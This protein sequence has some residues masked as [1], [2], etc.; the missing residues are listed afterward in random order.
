MKNI[1]LILSILFLALPQI[2]AAKNVKKEWR[3]YK[4]RGV[5]MLKTNYPKNKV[6][7]A[8]KGF[9]YIKGYEILDNYEIDGIHKFEK[10]EVR[11]FNPLE[12]EVD[13]N[14]YKYRIKR[15]KKDGTPQD[16]KFYYYRSN[17]PYQGKTA[18]GKRP[19]L[20]ISPTIKGILGG[21]FANVE[22]TW[23]NYFAARGINV[24]ILKLGEKLYTPGQKT[25]ELNKWIQ[26]KVIAIRMMVDFANETL[27]DE[28]DT[29]RVA[30]YGA[31]LGGIRSVIAMSLEPKERIAAGVTVATG[32]NFADLWVTSNQKEVVAMREFMMEIE[33]I[34]TN[35]MPAR[36]FSKKKKKL[37]KKHYKGVKDK[38]KY[39]NAMHEVYKRE[40]LYK[41]M[42][43]I[44]NVEPLQFIGLRK[45]LVED[46][47]MFISLKDSK[48][49]SKNQLELWQA[50]GQPEFSSNGRLNHSPYILLVA[51]LKLDTAF[52]EIQERLDK[53]LD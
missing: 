28:I 43:K 44:N 49:R 21:T 36:P 22:P 31:S 13:Y 17:I 8:A 45:T 32:G 47:F 11:I 15:M 37:Y 26:D 2:G 27:K 42:Q 35:F 39:D 6:L 5:H 23:A 30:L 33:G 46:L 14:I 3:K 50:I 34:N 52:A 9:D 41:I 48:V 12:H 53:V 10:N 16:I 51:K 20:I 18:A 19:L 25:L 7:A 29:K 4:K 40:K 38:D 24:I 1:A